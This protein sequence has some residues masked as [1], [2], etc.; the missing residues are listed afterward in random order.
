MSFYTPLLADNLSFH[1]LVPGSKVNTLTW[2]LGV[3]AIAD[4][5]GL[6]NI[7]DAKNLPLRLRNSSSCKLP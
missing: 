3:G 7:A 2:K 1:K 5:A 6:S 4:A